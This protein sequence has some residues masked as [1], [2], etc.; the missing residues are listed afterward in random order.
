LE[1]ELSVIFVGRRTKK[2]VTEF[3]LKTNNDLFKE[4]VKDKVLKKIN[5]DYVPKE[6]MKKLINEK[7][8]LINDLMEKLNINNV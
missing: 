2:G 4:K 5:E 7:D 3:N 1:E 8:K 6:Y